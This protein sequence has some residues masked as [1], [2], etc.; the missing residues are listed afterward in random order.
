MA[1]AVGQRTQEFGIRM[2]LGAER[3]SI[4]RLVL[5]QGLRLVA[6]G[7]VLGALASRL[8]GD[9]FGRLLYGVRRP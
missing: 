4:L 7:L 9:A 3:G 6:M 2:A 8:V 1:Y 5:G